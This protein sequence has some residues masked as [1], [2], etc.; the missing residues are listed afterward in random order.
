MGRVPKNNPTVVI[1]KA[2]P[3]YFFNE[4]TNIPNVIDIVILN[5][6]TPIN[7]T[8]IKLSPT[9]KNGIAKTVLKKAIFLI[10]K[11]SDNIPP[12]AFPIPIVKYNK[13]AC[14]W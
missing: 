14:I 8:T 4:E 11:Q 9:H 10:P 7:E 3:G 5:K 12:K 6:A 1:P 13:I 2:T